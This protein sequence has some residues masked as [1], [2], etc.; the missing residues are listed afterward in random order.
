[1]YFISFATV[2]WI[3]VFIR[4]EYKE[5]I[6]QSWQFCQENKGLDIYAWCIMP[7]HLHMLIG[8]HGKPLDHIVRDMKSYTSGQMR[9]LISEH[10]KESRREWMIWM[11]ERAGRK[12]GNNRDWQFWQQHNKPIEIVNE[13]M[14]NEIVWYI[15]QNPV[16][17]GFVHEA[18]Q[19]VYSSAKGYERNDGMV[20]L[21]VC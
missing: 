6:V 14:Y 10:P 1:M 20:K 3:D 2:N 12:N 4:N 15:H 21:A 11:F 8:T 13:K 17:S 5:A 19:W 16:V 18:A 9:K 7:S